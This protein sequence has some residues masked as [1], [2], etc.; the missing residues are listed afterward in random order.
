MFA[1]VAIK[2]MSRIIIPVIVITDIWVKV[3]KM[4]KIKY[5]VLFRF[6]LLKNPNPPG[7]Q[8]TELPACKLNF[9]TM[10]SR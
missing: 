7:K 6:T 5:N 10:A 3:V 2:R 4:K 8:T 1:A 9:D